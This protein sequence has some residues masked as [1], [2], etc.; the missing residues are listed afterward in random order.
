MALVEEQLATELSHFVPKNR[1]Q[2]GYDREARR[3]TDGALVKIEIK[4]RKKDS[5]VELVGNE[6]QAAKAA[7][8]NGEPFWVCIVPGI[9]EAPQLWIVENALT[10]GD[11]DTL[12]IDVNQWR[13][14][15]RR[16]L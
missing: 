5:P 9:P 12:K 13:I 15:G 4:G 14:H 2:V 3:R 7:F 1:Q 6:P 8:N 16:V 11:F 10:A